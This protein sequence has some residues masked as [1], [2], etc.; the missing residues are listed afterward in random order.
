VRPKASGAGLICRTVL[1]TT[2]HGDK[3]SQIRSTLTFILQPRRPRGANPQR[4]YFGNLQ[5]SRPNLQWC[6]EKNGWF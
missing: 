4:F 6:P 3:L 5:A 1:D 2:G